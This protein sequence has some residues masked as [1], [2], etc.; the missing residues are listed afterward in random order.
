VHNCLV[1]LSWNVSKVSDSGSSAAKELSCSRYG[2]LVLYC[3]SRL[4]KKGMYYVDNWAVLHLI[5]LTLSLNH[6]LVYDVADSRSSV[7]KY[8]LPK[9]ELL[10]FVLFNKGTYYGDTIPFCTLLV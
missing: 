10:G 1:V 7:M 5:C 8:L 9:M 2:C 4:D 6:L 3:S